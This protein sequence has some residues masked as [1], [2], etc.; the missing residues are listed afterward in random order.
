LEID[1]DLSYGR[2][3]IPLRDATIVQYTG[4]DGVAI[5][6]VEFTTAQATV[7]NF[8]VGFQAPAGSSLLTASFEPLHRHLPSAP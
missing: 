1:I 3:E 4:P 2:E 7:T 8:R 6:R 5:Q